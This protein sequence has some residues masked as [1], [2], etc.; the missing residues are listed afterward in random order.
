MILDMLLLCAIVLFLIFLVG[1]IMCHKRG[2]ACYPWMFK[3][4]KTETRVFYLLAVIFL[5]IALVIL[6]LQFPTWTCSNP[7]QIPSWQQNSCQ[8]QVPNK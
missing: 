7:S 8:V 6:Y 3:S 4:R 5:V 1:A 2:D